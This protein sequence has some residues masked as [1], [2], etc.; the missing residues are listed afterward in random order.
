M[1]ENVLTQE[2]SEQYTTRNPRFPDCDVTLVGTDNNAFSIIGIV[3]RALKSYL[4]EAGY[5]PNEVSEL[6]DQ[7]RNEAI[8][9][10]YNNVLITCMKWVNCN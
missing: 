8:S 9:G 1:N 4:R 3:A 2:N 6:L 5:S 10:D 7:F